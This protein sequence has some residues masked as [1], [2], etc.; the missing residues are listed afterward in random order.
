MNDANLKIIK[1]GYLSRDI[2][3]RYGS[4]M[5]FITKPFDWF[6]RLFPRFSDTL[7]VEVISQN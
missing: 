7:C 6:C 2:S 3:E 4:M 1:V 5:Q